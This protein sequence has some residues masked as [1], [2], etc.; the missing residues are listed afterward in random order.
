VQEAKEKIEANVAT[1]NVK[2]QSQLAKTHSLKL[3][4]AS[5]SSHLDQEKEKSQTLAHEVDKLM[6]AKGLLSGH[7]DYL[8]K[9]QE[10]MKMLLDKDRL[11]IKA[12]EEE[13][14][15]LKATCSDLRV[16]ITKG[17]KEQIKQS[18]RTV[19]AYEARDKS[20]DY[21][22]LMTE[23]TRKATALLEVVKKENNMLKAKINDFE[24]LQQDQTASK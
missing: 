5:P 19:V 15:K 2:I 6:A 8:V 20:R 21:L 10:Q 24:R 22:K 17:L 11:T 1:L 23:S 7:M 12:L 4:C 9:M 14:Q 16:Q 3:H 13:N 18:E